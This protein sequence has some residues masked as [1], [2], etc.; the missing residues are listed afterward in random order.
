MTINVWC[1]RYYQVE[2]EPRKVSIKDVM[3]TDK[4][5]D[6]G[7]H[8]AK[9]VIIVGYAIETRN[10]KYMSLCIVLSPLAGQCVQLFRCLVLYPMVRVRLRWFVMFAKVLCKHSAGPSGVTAVTGTPATRPASTAW[11]HWTRTLSALAVWTE[12]LG[13]SCLLAICSR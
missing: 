10:Y 5:T 4:E 6:I 1:F 7:F 13:M 2:N 8:P 11:F 12:N 9:P 3:C